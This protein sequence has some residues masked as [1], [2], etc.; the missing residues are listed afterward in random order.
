MRKRKGNNMNKE[1][2]A[3]TRTLDCK[4]TARSYWCFGLVNGKLAE[5]FYENGKIFGHAYV[6][7]DDYKTKREKQWIRSDTQKVQLSFRKGVYRNKL[8]NRKIPRVNEADVKKEA[9][10]A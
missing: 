6:S 10:Q 9:P 5:I 3:N 2:G 8:T 4:K 1:R 7:A